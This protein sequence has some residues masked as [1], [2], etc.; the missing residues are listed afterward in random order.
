MI[1]TTFFCHSLHAPRPTTDEGNS[2][3]MCVIL[4]YLFGLLTCKCCDVNGYFG[5]SKSP[6]YLSQWGV[7]EK[8]RGSDLS[9]FSACISI[10]FPKLQFHQS[11]VF[12]RIPHLKEI[13][14]LKTFYLLFYKWNPS[15]RSAKHYLEWIPLGKD[16]KIIF[17]LYHNGAPCADVQHWDILLI[18]HHLREHAPRKLLELCHEHW[19]GEKEPN[20]SLR[21][22]WGVG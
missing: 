21:K 17:K 12:I 3:K 1:S 2:L 14:V 7:T 4:Q 9:Y 20:W 6:F 19:Q 10:L 11:A 8:D 18:P 5:Q 15:S 16:I 13:S 22:N